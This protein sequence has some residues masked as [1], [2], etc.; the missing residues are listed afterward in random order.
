MLAIDDTASLELERLICVEIAYESHLGEACRAVAVNEGL[1]LTQ[2]LIANIFPQSLL[3]M[4][5]A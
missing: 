4:Q 5:E 2:Y 1:G 3:A